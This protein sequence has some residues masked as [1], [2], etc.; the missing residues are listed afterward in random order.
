MAGP[1]S[2]GQVAWAPVFA[3]EYLGSDEIQQFFHWGPQKVE[4]YFISLIYSLPPV[5]TCFTCHGLGWRVTEGIYSLQ[6]SECEGSFATVL[7]LFP[8]PTSS[9]FFFNCHSQFLVSQ[10]CLSIPSWLAE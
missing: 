10:L 8:S 5:E 7:A 1:G 3:K 2:S 4:R 6:D 9:G